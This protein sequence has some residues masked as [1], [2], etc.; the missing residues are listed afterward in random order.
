MTRG[1]TEGKGGVR[2]PRGCRV[3]RSVTA[4]KGHW[5]EEGAAWGGSDKGLAES[6]G[7]LGKTKWQYR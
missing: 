1:V 3:A 4:N 2:I 6:R 5:A 7:V